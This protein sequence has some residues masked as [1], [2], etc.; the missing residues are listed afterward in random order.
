MKGGATTTDLESDALWTI[1]SE[2]LS[3]DPS[4]RL[5]F[6]SVS[7]AL[8]ASQAEIEGTESNRNAAWLANGT[9]S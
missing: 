2:C 8:L 4:R 5:G 1:L 6:S 7:G 9:V 3:V